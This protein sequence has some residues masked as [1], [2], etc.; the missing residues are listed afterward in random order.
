MRSA[1]AAMRAPWTIW[2]AD[3]CAGK[4]VDANA[5]DDPRNRI[6]ATKAGSRSVRL[7]TALHLGLVR[8]LQHLIGGRNRLRVRLIGALRDDHVHD[9]RHD[10][11]VGILQVPALKRPRAVEPRLRDRRRAGR[12]GLREEVVALG[13]EPGGVDEPRKIDLA[14]L[15][16]LRLARQ[17]RGDRPVRV[18]RDARRLLRD[19]YLRTEQVA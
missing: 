19:R 13:L 1:K 15:L 12:G 4:P 10:G 3:E 14:D 11:D 6:A 16:R 7:V 2:Y 18:D 8:R 9:L 17:E 5:A